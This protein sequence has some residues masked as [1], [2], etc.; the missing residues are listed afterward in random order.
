MRTGLD[1]IEAAIAGNP[2]RDRRHAIAHLVYVE[3]PDGRRF[4]E[5]GVVAQ[6]SANWM[7]AGP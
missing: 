5:L 6:F 7:S 1:S 4:G 3:D 2:P